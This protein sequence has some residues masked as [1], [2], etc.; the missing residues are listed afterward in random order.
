[1]NRVWCEI[2][3]GSDESCLNGLQDTSWAF[4]LLISN[5]LLTGR[6]LD[7]LSQNYLHISPLH[8][9]RNTSFVCMLNKK[10]FKAKVAQSRTLKIMTKNQNADN[11]SVS[12]PPF[13][14]FGAKTAN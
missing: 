12:L 11:R 13:P 14:V 2:G 6:S 8:W 4:A 3:K 10:E 5:V 1:M 7:S 9:P